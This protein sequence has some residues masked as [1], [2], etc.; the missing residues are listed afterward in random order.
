MRILV[1]QISGAI[2]RRIISS[3]SPGDQGRAGGLVGTIKYGSRTEIYARRR[4]RVRQFV[5][6]LEGPGGLTV[7][8]ER[9]GLIGARNRWKST[10][11][12]S[13]RTS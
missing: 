11:T 3:V 10:E 13:F 1:K 6:G 7:L 2:A 8:A 12:C 5:A 4:A 9:G